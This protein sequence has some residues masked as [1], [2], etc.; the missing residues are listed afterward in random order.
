MRKHKV[1]MTSAPN[2]KCRHIVHIDAEYYLKSNN[3]EKA[4]TAVLVETEKKRLHSI[5]VPALGTGE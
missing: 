3:W 5:A 4:Y 1:V 2:L